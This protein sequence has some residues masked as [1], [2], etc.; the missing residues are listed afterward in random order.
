MI[1]RLDKTILIC[2]LLLSGAGLLSLWTQAPVSDLSGASVTKSIFL[3]QA[4]FLGIGLA[5]MGLVALPHYHLFRRV[6]WVLWAACVI[7]LVVLLAK[8]TYIKGARHW[9]S[10][11]VITV[12]PAEFCKIACVL[13]VARVL[14][15]TRNIQSWRGLVLPLVLI[16][17][18]CALIVV[19]PDL[20][21]TLLFIPALFAMLFTAGA[22]KR[23]LAIVVLVIAA[24]A[25][26]AWKWGMKDYQKNRIL[27]FMFPDRVSIDLT[28][29]QQN[30]V[31]A[32]SA[33]GVIGRGLGEGGSSAVFYVPERH[34]DFVYSIIAEELGFVGSTFVLLLLV[35]YF[36]R[37]YWIA[38]QSRE[39]FGRLV[40]VGLTTLFATQSI[41][42]IGMTL[43]VAPITGVT[44]P[45]V[46]YGG[47]SLLACCIGTGI[48]LNVS[49]RWQPG[50]SSRDMAG[51]SVE[52]SNFQPQAV[53][54]LAH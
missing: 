33:G 34:T 44:L 39:P 28:M 48:V 46:S 51:G 24:G 50:F 21:S 38:H 25:A 22:R 30:S 1:G 14:M 6:A 20:G 40:V 13:T 17:V 52:I 37:S 27:S 23:H 43:G 8:G 15:Y 2:V 53:K 31:R 35:I 19:Q 5:V 10:L 36:G 41:V 4:T 3:K 11:G 9:F 16:A 54:W 12:Q 26:P 47:S 42:N 49:A 32:C 45:F 7:A 29:Q 18:P